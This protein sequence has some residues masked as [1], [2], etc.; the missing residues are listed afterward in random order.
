MA[1]A[2]LLLSL[3]VGLSGA[4]LP[5]RAFPF[6]WVGPSSV[7]VIRTE[8]VLGIFSQF[9]RVLV[10][11]MASLVLIF[12]GLHFLIVLFLIMRHLLFV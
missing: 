9:I 10:V 8:A 11:V 3:L 6:C 5:R 2:M 4:L 1:P 12:R 7:V